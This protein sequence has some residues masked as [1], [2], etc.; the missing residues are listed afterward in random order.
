PT[1]LPLAMIY[2]IDAIVLAAWCELREDFRHFRLDRITMA[3]RLN[4]PFKD[5]A[6]SLRQKWRETTNLT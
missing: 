6:V 5:R 4:T 1:I 3:D 2:Y